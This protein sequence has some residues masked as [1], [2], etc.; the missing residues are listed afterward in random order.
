MSFSG[1]ECIPVYLI[2]L[3][4]QY[5]DDILIVKGVERGKLEITG[6]VVEKTRRSCQVGSNN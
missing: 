1:I 4:L 2:G 3:L 6:R 5:L